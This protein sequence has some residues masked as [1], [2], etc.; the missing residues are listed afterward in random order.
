[1]SD[2]RTI[3]FLLRALSGPLMQ[4]YT[5]KSVVLFHLVLFIEVFAGILATFLSTLN[6]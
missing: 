2:V 1:V 3:I 6:T 4:I 5:V